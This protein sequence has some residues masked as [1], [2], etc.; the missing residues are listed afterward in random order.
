MRKYILILPTLLIFFQCTIES[1]SDP[2]DIFVLKQYKATR[3]SW[4]TRSWNSDGTISQEKVYSKNLPEFEGEIHSNIYKN[5]EYLTGSGWDLEISQIILQGDTVWVVTN[6]MQNSVFI[7]RP[8]DL[9]QNADIIYKKTHEAFSIELILRSY[10]CQSYNKDGVRITNGLHYGGGDTYYN[11]NN[12]LKD[13][14]GRSDTMYIHLPSDL[15]I[16]WRDDCLLM[17]KHIIIETKEEELSLHEYNVFKNKT[18][19]FFE[20]SINGPGTY[21]IK[22]VLSYPNSL[23]LKE[24]ALHEVIPYYS[25]ETYTEESSKIRKF[26]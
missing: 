21:A 20:E 8:I 18:Q 10:I 3:T 5:E 19:A 22:E 7:S 23:D 9:Y 24:K 25:M 4:T 11:V 13:N 1:Q 14:I 17:E 2:S 6:I 12:W 16:P 26:H 15:E